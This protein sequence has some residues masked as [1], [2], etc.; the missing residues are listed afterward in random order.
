ML[1]RNETREYIQSEMQ[2]ASQ[3]EVVNYLQG[4]NANE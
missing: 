3:T 4:I 1:Q 2:R